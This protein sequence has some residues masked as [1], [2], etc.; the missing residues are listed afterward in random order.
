MDKTCEWDNNKLLTESGLVKIKA[1]RNFSILQLVT[2]SIVA[3]LGVA[4]KPIIVPLVHIITGPLFIPGG[5][6]AGGFYMFWVVLGIGLVKKR[7]TGTLIGL[8][9]GLLVIVTGAMGTHGILS[10]ISYSLP[11]IAADLIFIWSRDNKYTI[12]H[13]ILGSLSANVV[14]TMISNAMFFR[15]P[16]ETLLILLTGA[17]LSGAI[18]GV[19]AWNILIAINKLNLDF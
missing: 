16:M 5:A 7:G 8:I 9:Q 4:T 15:L 13:F 11:G 19:L 14:G 2:I 6:I 17:A 12:I 10:I 18:G 1:L 3:A